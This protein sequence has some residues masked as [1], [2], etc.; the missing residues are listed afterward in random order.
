MTIFAYFRNRI[1][2]VALAMAACTL[3]V[4]GTASPVLAFGNSNSS[5]SDGVATMNDLKETSKQA[6]KAEPRDTK[7]VQSKAQGGLN[8][9]QGSA[10]LDKMNAPEN[11][12][13]A[14][15]VSDQ[16]EDMLEG[17]TPGN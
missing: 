13:A 10:N 3:L 9:V 12:Q 1:M 17:L 5:P 11:S 15:T 8:S 16:V 2:K 6:V 7:E 14:T 4:L